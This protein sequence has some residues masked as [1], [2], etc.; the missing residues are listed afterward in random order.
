MYF[1]RFGG[2]QDRSNS[3][4]SGVYVLEAGVSNLWAEDPYLPVRSSA[5]LD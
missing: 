4:P 5:A 3:C 1:W 2:E